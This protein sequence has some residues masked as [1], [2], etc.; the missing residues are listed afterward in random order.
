MERDVDMLINC[1]I[2]FGG[3]GEGEVEDPAVRRHKGRV[4]ALRD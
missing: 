1:G 3:G 4:R 2:G